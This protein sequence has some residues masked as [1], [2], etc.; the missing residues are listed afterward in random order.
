[1]GKLFALRGI[2]NVGKTSVLRLLINTIINKYPNANLVYYSRKTNKDI[3]VTIDISI[4]DVKIKIGVSTEGDSPGIALKGNLKIFIDLSCDIIFCA[5]KT[6]GYTNQYINECSNKY[7]IEY[8]SKAKS[9]LPDNS[10]SDMNIVK[11]LMAKTGI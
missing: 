7:T 3:C 9:T 2:S 6:S 8:I 5:C 10:A 11:S 4:N 1:M